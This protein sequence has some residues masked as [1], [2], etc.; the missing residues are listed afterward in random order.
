MDQA[1]C[2]P[3]APAAM[4]E[5]PGPL[6][7]PWNGPD[8]LAIE[9]GAALCPEIGRGIALAEVLAIGKGLPAAHHLQV[10]LLAAAQDLSHGAATAVGGQHP[11]A[12]IRTN[13]SQ[14]SQQAAGLGA[15]GALGLR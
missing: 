11:Q 14:A 9:L 5:I 4:A 3:I 7:A 15:V 12:Y 6:N 2:G 10:H 13:R 1:G 8:A